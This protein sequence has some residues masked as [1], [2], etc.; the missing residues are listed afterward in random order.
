MDIKR[1]PPK[2]RKKWIIG[3]VVG[4]GLVAM[5]VAL[6]TLEPA[7]PT[8][9][10]PWLDTVQQGNM[11]VEVRGPGTLVPENPRWI[12]AVTAGRVERLNLLPGDSVKP[13]TVILELT[14]PDV[15]I[16]TLNADRALTDS[17]SQL[18]QLKTSLAS[19]RLTQA[20]AVSQRRQEWLDAQ[21]RAEAGAELLKK[22]L[23]IPLDQKQAEDRAAALGE[24]VKHEE[25]RLKILT[26]TIDEQIKVQERQ[27]ERL[28]SIA[29]FQHGLKASMVVR[30][31]ANGVLQE[32]PL[33]IGQYANPGAVLARVVPSPLR[34]KAVLRIPET[35]ANGITI[36]QLAKID[37]RNGIANGKVSR[38]DPAAAAGTVTIDVAL[39]STLPPGARPDLS[40]DGVIEIARLEN[41]LFMGR[42]AYGQSDATVGLF[43]LVQD[44]GHAERV[45][46]RLGRTS[47]NAVEIREGLAPGD[48]VIL[49]DMTRWDGVDRVRIK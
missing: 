13:E 48:V 31:G 3:G 12:S 20:S 30:A 32:V 38:I 8:V 33:Q 40:V 37:T 11:V 4:T 16:Q 1:E 49:S 21:R 6:A 19:N 43:K 44:G 25:E 42:P 7:A 24:Q 28:R 47:V 36:G 18:V 34:L 22:G 10:A 2:N 45:S 23:I 35:Q 17:E 26:E 9:E 29:Q 14:N 15:E 39:D 46:V 27:V 41:V 5:T